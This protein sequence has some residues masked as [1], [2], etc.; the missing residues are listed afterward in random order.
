MTALGDALGYTLSWLHSLI[1][2][3]RRML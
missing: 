1:M 2:G 3:G